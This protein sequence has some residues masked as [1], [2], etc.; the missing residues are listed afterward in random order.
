MD[1]TSSASLTD[2]T[3]A[4]GLEVF[5]FS[6]RKT[7]GSRVFSILLVGLIYEKRIASEHRISFS[8]LGKMG[9]HSMVQG[10]ATLWDS[11]C[12][13]SWWRYVGATQ[14]SDGRWD[15]AYT[16]TYIH[17]SARLIPLEAVLFCRTVRYTLGGTAAHNLYFMERYGWCLD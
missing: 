1:S 14:H 2:V 12:W 16:Y 7:M 4:D 9:I 13:H 11:L 3:R 6:S 8:F 17:F 15:G 10:A 5:F